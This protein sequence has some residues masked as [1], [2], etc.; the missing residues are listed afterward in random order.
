MTLHRRLPPFAHLPRRH[1]LLALA[2]AGLQACAGM[3]RPLA[4][5]QG[6]TVAEL[7]APHYRF[8]RFGLDSADGQRHYRVQLALPQAAPP[9]AGY[10]L[11]VLLDGN[12]AFA[13]LSADTLAQLA[14][15]GRPP[16]IAAV[17]YA[18]E[19]EID[20]TARSFDYTPPVP[21]EHPTWDNAARTRQGGGADLFLDLLAQQILPEIR[22][23][24]PTDAARSTLWGHSYGGLLALYT[25]FTRPQL[26][27]RYAAADPSLWWHDGFILA[28]EQRAAPLP[29]GRDTALLL[30][31]GGSALAQPARASRRAVLQDAAPQLAERQAR[32]PGMALAWQPFPG[33]G[34]G[35][36][37]P[38]SMPAT[39]EFATQ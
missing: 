8:E 28:V 33:V 26:F 29:A 9:A 15:S 6:P 37:R 36:M 35:P 12:A 11:L 4:Q 23:R 2:G 1:L 34:H 17:G 14:T 38:A 39:L 13:L 21:G 22:R 25:L 5:P 3:A 20:I 31:T 16:A 18:S 19:R 32:R 24:A 10:P 27:A 7:G 30:M